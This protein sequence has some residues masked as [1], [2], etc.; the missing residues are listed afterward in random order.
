MEACVQPR[1]TG[2]LWHHSCR[3]DTTGW[4]NL[5]PSSLALSFSSCV[6]FPL[7]VPTSFSHVTQRTFSIV[8]SNQEMHVRDTSLILMGTVFMGDDI[9]SCTPNLLWDKP[10]NCFSGHLAYLTTSLLKDSCVCDWKA[11]GLIWDSVGKYSIVEYNHTTSAPY[12]VVKTISLSS[13]WC[14]WKEHQI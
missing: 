2:Q 11:I 13:R 10:H 9:Y 8:T 4:E 1:Q 6:V 7:S 12:N 5:T 14:C 3:P